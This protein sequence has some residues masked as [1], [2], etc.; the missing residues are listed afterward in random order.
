MSEAQA[1]RLSDI[2]RA[3][4]PK[5]YTSVSYATMIDGELYA[6]EAI[7]VQNLETKVAA[8]PE[9]TCNVA[10]ISKVFCTVAVMLLVERGKITLD[11]PVVNYLPKFK[12]MDPRYTRISLRHCLAHTSG[13]PGTQ[14]R[15]FAVSN[16]DGADYY[17]DVYD[18]LS[19]STLK[20][21]PGAYSVYCN[22]GFTLAEMVVAEI[23]GESF[24]EYC[25]KNITDPIGA[26]STRLA[27]NHNEKNPLVSEGKKPAEFPLICGGAGFTTTMVDLCKFGKLFLEKNDII[28]QESM[29][30]MAKMQGRSF[31]TN[32]DRSRLYGL[33]WDN[34]NF[35]EPDYDLGEGTLIKGGNSFQFNSRLMVVPKHNAVIAISA[36][37]DCKLDVGNLALR[38]LAAMLAS[39]GENVCA[40]AV[41]VACD[42]AEKFGGTYL[43]P[44]G[45][46]NL[47][48][49]GA[50]ADFT[51]D[52]VCGGSVPMLLNLKWVGDCFVDDKN[53]AYYFEEQGGDKFLMS[54]TKGYNS[55]MMM[56]AKDFDCEPKEW[57]A[58]VGKSYVVANTTATDMVIYEMM[59]GFKV[60][61]LPNYKG[62]YVL[63]FAGR[64]DS[65]V[66]S[67]FESTV[68]A[69]D[70][71][72][73]RAFLRTP[74]NPSRDLPD[75]IFSM[76]D[77]VEFCDAVS[78]GY[79]DTNSLPEYKGEAEFPIGRDN[80]VFAIKNELC[81]LPEIPEGHRIMVMDENLIAV[82]DS[83]FSKEYKP[84]KTGYIS[85]I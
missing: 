29:R 33:G 43:A 2:V 53:N 75:P 20:D 51:H 31:L 46:F 27:Y 35:H 81:S 12:M 23:S 13:M 15:G 80:N 76:R 7:G 85:L 21:E 69:I 34:M 19:K 52:F 11:E 24:H 9:C 56:H 45:V 42:I 71:N 64:E 59:T 17:A 39:R 82:Y 65:G 5:E 22:D 63:S 78:Y 26:S 44:F 25:K 16:P 18:Y 6:A 50:M 30:E 49:D 79:V 68:R 4:L 48:I 8:T 57:E 60:C 47:R 40:E 70:A 61:K 66:Y 83:L 74:C 14:W 72:T 10:S 36:T 58:R 32:D 77:G 28:S 73:G 62:V 67:L 54:E 41:P 38:L 84:V 55:P 1:K 3:A 37:H